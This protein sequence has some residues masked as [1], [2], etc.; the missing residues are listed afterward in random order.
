MV[1]ININPQRDL[2]KWGPIDVKLFYPSFFAEA[3]LLKVRE[4]YAWFWPTNLSIFLRGKFI[5]INDA[6]KLKKVGEKYFKKYFLNIENYQR[7]WQ[8]WEKWIKQYQELQNKFSKI[9]FPQ[10]TNRELLKLFR[11]FYYLEIDFWL[12]VHVPEIAN[13]GGEYLLGKKLKRINPE[14]AEEYLEILS[15]PIKYS[16]FQKEEIELLK[17]SLIKDKKELKKALK[18]HAQKYCWLLNSYG[19]NRVLTAKYFEEKLRNILKE[20]SAQEKMKMI[21]N[22]I[23]QSKLRK[24][25]LA[26]KLKLDKEIILIYQQLSQS[27]WWQDLRK[28]YI[29]QMHYLWDKLLK[30]ITKRTN[31]SFGELLWAWPNEVLK[32]LQGQKVDKNR[33]L[34]RK[35]YYAFYSEKGRIK[36]FYG[37]KVKDLIKIYLE[38]FA[39]QQIKEFK[40]LI[41]SKGKEGRIIKG[42]VKIIT[43]P[44]KES[45]KMQ[46]GD[47]LVAGMTSPEFIVVIKKAKAIITDHGGMTCHAAIVSREMGIPCLVRT[48]I[49]TKAL[50]DNDIVEID[51]DKSIVKI[52]KKAE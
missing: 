37:Q 19:G 24:E 9:K 23:K 43:N 16:F 12:I 6:Q 15:A 30:E 32:I 4:Y 3:I 41:V 7:L 27:I 21:E 42:K 31:F 8:K 14:K 22:N 28:G 38:S 17:I 46:K 2:F 11:E 5:W 35:K 25:G 10:I 26:K 45:N 47:I 40:G 51:V 39:G 1:K 34:S 18:K 52:I 33:I 13:W 44:F 48:K 29:W 20:S 50:H 36:H 49:A